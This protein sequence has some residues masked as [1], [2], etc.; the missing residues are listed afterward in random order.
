MTHPAQQTGVDTADRAFVLERGLVP[1]VSVR[2]IAQM[3]VGMVRGQGPGEAIGEMQRRRGTKMVRVPLVFMDIVLAADPEVAQAIALNSDESF[4]AERAWGL[5]LTGMFRKALLQKE[6]AEHRHDRLIIQRSLTPEKIAGYMDGMAATV[7]THVDSL[8][9][10]RGVQL[11]KLFKRVA[12]EAALTNFVGLD[13]TEDDIYRIGKAFD[14][15]VSANPLAQ[16]RARRYLHRT[17]RSWV[18]IKRASLTP[19]LMSQLCHAS[20]VNGD[21]FTDDDVMRH[22]MFFLFAAHDTTTITMT[23]MA[24]YI[25]LNR[26]W[27]ARARRESLALGETLS[28]ADL[29]R[30]PELDKILR[31]TLRFRTP[32]PMMQR[33]AVRRT[34]LVGYQI[35]RNTLIATLTWGH[36]TN[37]DVWENPTRFDPDRFAVERAEDKRHPGLWM[38]FGGG[39]H[40]CVGMHFARMEVFSLFHQLL[41][42]YEWSV[43]ND[44]VLPTLA[45]SLVFSNGFPAEVRR[46]SPTTSDGDLSGPDVDIQWG[47]RP[48]LVKRLNLGVNRERAGNSCPV[49]R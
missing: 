16:A 10:G 1:R 17:L 30:L 13:F 21:R 18:P 31:E 38:P 14:D 49:D 27:Q 40:K 35:R 5:T 48:K 19:D 7:A 12:M 23:N 4:S 2:D 3:T 47:I 44:F 8:A 37:P 39:A 32:V 33:T 36:H 26:K 43:E 25:G 11:R 15:L 42:K 6:F 34:R 28:Y 29:K 46:Y 20:A 45:N 9:V 24:Y 22:M 41:R